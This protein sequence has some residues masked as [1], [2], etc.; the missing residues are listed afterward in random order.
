LIRRAVAKLGVER[1]I[2][3]LTAELPDEDVATEAI[4]GL[5]EPT[6]Q[7][8]QLL[9]RVFER[10]AKMFDRRG[11]DK[12]ARA[13]DA[14]ALEC[15]EFSVAQETGRFGGRREG[16]GHRPVLAGANAS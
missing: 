6:A 12:P 1:E 16:S 2:P 10:I 9:D 4:A 5:I 15:F 14:I 3:E 11:V 13:N 8:T 7:H